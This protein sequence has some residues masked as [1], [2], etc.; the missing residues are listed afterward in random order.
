MGQLFITST[1]LVLS[2]WWLGFT[3]DETGKMSA[4]ESDVESAVCGSFREPFMFWLWHNLAGTV[5]P[6][7][8][9]NVKNAQQIQFKTR[10]G[11]LLGGY[12]IAAEKPHGYLLVAQGNAMLA[13]QLVADLQTF[14]DHGW[15]VY[16]YDYRG[17]G[18]SQG[19]SRLAAIVD[20]YREIVGQLN[21]LSYA[22]RFLYGMSMGGVILLNAVGSTDLYTGFVIDSSP[23]RISNL[24]CPERYDP[25][26][27]LPKDSG[28]L[29]LISGARDT[30]VPGRQMD[31]LIRAAQSRGARILQDSE[32]AHPYQDA[33]LELHRRR[34]HEVVSFL[35]SIEHSQHRE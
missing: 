29:M 20:D 22:K 7:R 14:R 32:F 21:T 24:G 33:S 25:V 35:S 31:E 11:I 16:V 15:D 6:Q 1:L 3:M 23:A 8:V 28:P 2:F 30:V 17:Y 27:H 34:Q 19:K 9:A 4:S 5:N 13:D 10:D 26:N 18:I 12:K